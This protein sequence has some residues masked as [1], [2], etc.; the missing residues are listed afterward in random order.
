MPERILNIKH[1]LQEEDRERERTVVAKMRK[2]MK[3]L[4]KRAEK[5]GV[6]ADGEINEKENE[7]GKEERVKEG[8]QTTEK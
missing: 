1:R 8:E 7:K 4:R 6:K 3:G 2:C 5:K